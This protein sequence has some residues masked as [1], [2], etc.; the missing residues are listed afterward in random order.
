M[1]LGA[2]I[3]L[4]Q[5]PLCDRCPVAAICAHQQHGSLEMRRKTQSPHVKLIQRYTLQVSDGRVRL[6][7]RNKNEP[8]MAGMWELP[9]HRRGGKRLGAVRHAITYRTITAE[10]WEKAQAGEETSGRK[11]ESHY[12]TR[13]QAWAL[14]LTGLS[15]KILRQFWAEVI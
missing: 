13:R 4:P 2:T 5:G 8:L 6:E 12:F 7:R 15:R 1:E 11:S 10:V 14:P 3:C 9:R